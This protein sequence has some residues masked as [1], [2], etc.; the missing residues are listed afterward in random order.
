MIDATPVQYF[1]CP[2]PHYIQVHLPQLLPQ[3][4]Q[5]VQSVLIVLQPCAES[6]CATSAAIDRQ[7]QTRR[8]RF[9]HLAQTLAQDL[10]QQGY[11]TDIF[12]PKT[13]QPLL[14]AAGSRRLEDA[15]VVRD[16]L[17]YD[18]KWCGDCRVVDHPV[19]GDAVYPAVMVSAAPPDRLEAIARSH[20]ETF[21]AQLKQAQLS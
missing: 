7:K 6:L 17:G 15:A 16:C 4:H 5:P 18:L 12:D 8:Q 14:S 3:W 10:Q 9:L 1:V 11:Q 13:G 19:W 21:L 2:P 20:I